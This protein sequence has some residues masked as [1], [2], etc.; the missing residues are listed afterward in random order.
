M[1][2]RNKVIKKW[3]NIFKA[4]LLQFS[5]RFDSYIYL[6]FPTEKIISIG[7]IKLKLLLIQNISSVINFC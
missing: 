3:I 4:E 7:P 5:P 6:M 2:W 1:K